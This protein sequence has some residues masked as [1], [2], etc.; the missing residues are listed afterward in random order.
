MK[1]RITFRRLQTVLGQDVWVV[2]IYRQVEAF[3]RRI[4]VHDFEILSDWTDL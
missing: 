3:A 2:K 4:E 1:L